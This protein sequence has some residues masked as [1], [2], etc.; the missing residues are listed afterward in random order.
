MKLRSDMEQTHLV[1]TNEGKNKMT[2]QVPLL[3]NSTEATKGE[4]S[5]ISN[6]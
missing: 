1:A 6:I 4:R 3:S 5:G 2:W